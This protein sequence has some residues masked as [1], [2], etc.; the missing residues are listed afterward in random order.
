MILYYFSLKVNKIKLDSTSAVKVGD[1]V[2]SDTW[3]SSE[4]AINAAE[5]NGGSAFRKEYRGCHISATLSEAV[6][7]NSYPSWYITYNSPVENLYIIINALTGEFISGRTSP[8]ISAFRVNK[9]IGN[10]Q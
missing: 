2:I 10:L 3:V 1:S 4:T 6:V 7:P 8:A 5:K 9:V